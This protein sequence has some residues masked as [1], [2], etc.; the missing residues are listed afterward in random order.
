MPQRRLRFELLE[1][2]Q[3]LS[4]T[5]DTLVDEMNGVGTGAGTSLREAIAA[6]AADETI[7]FSVTGVINLTVGSS[8]SSK[9]LTINKSLTINGPGANL[10]TI[11]A[12]D[13]TSAT[14]NGDGSRVFTID[15]ANAANLL[16]VSISGL[17]LTG[18]D[19]NTAG[20]AIISSENLVVTDCVVSG[21]T[22]VINSLYYGGGGIHSKATIS[23]PNSLTIRSS[24]LTGN[25]A[26]ASEG[27]AIR[28]R[29]G[30]LVIENCTINNNSA[31][32]AGGG[33]SAADGN[34]MVQ[35]S[36][37]TLS[38]NQAT[39]NFGF[40]SGGAIF[41][42]NARLNLTGSTISGN[43]S[44]IG[45]GIEA[46]GGSTVTIADSLLSSNTAY[47]NGGG[48]EIVSSSLSINRSTLS[49]NT[50][51][52]AGGG[53]KTNGSTLH[54]L[55]S[56]LSGNSAR[57]GG[58]IYG[59]SLIENST[60]SG[61]TASNDMGAIYSTGGATIIRFSTISGN[62]TP[63]N[64]N[65]AIGSWGKATGTV[66]V[67]SSIVAGNTG[68]DIGYKNNPVPFASQGYNLIGTGNNSSLTSFNQPGDQTGI[69]NPM[70]GALADNG[71]STKTRAPLPDSPAIDAGNPAAMPGMNNVP[72]Y[73]QRGTPYARIVD[74]DATV[75]ARIDIGAVESQTQ[76]L[77]PAIF[78]DYNVDGFVDAA[79]EIVWRKSLGASGVPAYF[80]ADGSG[81][82]SVGP[83]DLTVWR[84][85]FGSTVPATAAHEVQPLAVSTE[86]IVRDAAPETR[87]ALRPE[88]SRSA[89]IETVQPTSRRHRVTATPPRAIPA[90]AYDAA[91]LAWTA[92]F[93]RDAKHDIG[94]TGSDAMRSDRRESPTSAFD[95]LGAELDSLDL[96]RD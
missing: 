78:G 81:N 95:V 17:T 33:L 56:T 45:G 69:L 86:P 71:G 38:Q 48:I 70:L 22:T 29:F 8:N 43:T 30:N 19:V 62:S 10:L 54:L 35:I 96:L 6:A 4:I 13:P 47:N 74:G 16:N 20:G 36:G 34:V 82:G 72:L 24:T 83:E 39:D 94:T 51:G 32:N 2:R 9:Q 55:S 73:D 93:G 59:Q 89:D 27:G 61:N 57:Y 41:A 77:P 50:A 42:K 63:V 25:A 75:D 90:S 68:G 91:L 26:T 12:F 80:G 3:L 85:Y 7:D 28:Q 58:A 40:G 11:K 67:L 37:S 31:R 87:T 49:G 21:N 60:I 1:S 53:I 44:N 15:D 5:V 14:K 23:K 64:R 79:D 88:T 66:T 65:G 76:P 52:F 84:A 92:T 18:G 46:S